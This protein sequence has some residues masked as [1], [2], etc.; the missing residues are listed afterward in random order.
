MVRLLNS[1]T[2]VDFS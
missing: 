1:V 2:K